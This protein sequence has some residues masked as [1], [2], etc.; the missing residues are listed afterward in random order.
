MSS[1]G[2]RERERHRIKYFLSCCLPCLSVCLSRGSRVQS[3]D[4]F[5]FCLLV[6]PGTKYHRC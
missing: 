1:V 3:C 5:Y 2:E 6:V 4:K